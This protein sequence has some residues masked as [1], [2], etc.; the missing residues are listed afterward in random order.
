MAR[1]GAVGDV[2][3]APRLILIPGFWPGAG[4]RRILGSNGPLQPQD[5][6][7]KVGGEAPHLFQWVLQ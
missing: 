5:P 7:A 1:V 2:V 4:K 6:L 3:G